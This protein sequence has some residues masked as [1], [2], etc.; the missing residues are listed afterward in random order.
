MPLF[1]D[2]KYLEADSSYARIVPIRYCIQ[3]VCKENK[4]VSPR[5]DNGDKI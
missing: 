3:L 5:F 1:P 2:R 4:M